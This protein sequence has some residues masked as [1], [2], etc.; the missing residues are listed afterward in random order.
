MTKCDKSTY[1]PF[2]VLMSVYRNDK[3]EELRLAVESVTVRQTLPPDE[4]VLVV[5]GPIAEPL[6]AEIDALQREIGTIRPVWLAENG[7][8]GRALRIGMEQVAH[9]LVARMD[10]DDI[11]EPT[12]F[13]KQV[14][15]L[16]Q[17]P[18]IAV[19]GGQMT[20]FIGDPANVV[21][22]RPVPLEAPAVRRYFRDRDPLN[23]VTVMLRRSAVLAAGNYQPWHLDEDTYLWGRLLERG[24]ELANL[25]DVLVSARVGAEMYARRGGW[26]YF[27]S[28]VGI[29]RWKYRHG[30][31]GP[32]RFMYNY[33]VR[34]VVQVLM[35]NKMRGW[36]FR[37]FLRTR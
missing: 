31:T 27:R 9:E 14:R 20:E 37:T 28:D 19:V 4:V 10:S 36:L 7:G 32:G 34:F 23:H 1:P 6:K 13:E 16:E 5:D 26:R 15:Y 17:H 25:P 33:L 11:S 22:M 21:A 24:Y 30:L 35:P 18:D 3:P 2:C 29:L 12:R 8:L